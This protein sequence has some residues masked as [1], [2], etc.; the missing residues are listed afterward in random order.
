MKAI[1]IKLDTKVVDIPDYRPVWREL[2]RPDGFELE[3]NY[4]GMSPSFI[5]HELKTVDYRVVRIAGGKDGENGYYLVNDEM[6]FI[7][8]PLIRDIIDSNRREL[9]HT[10][11]ELKILTTHLDKVKTDY[12]STWYIRLKNYAEKTKLSLVKK[13]S[14]RTE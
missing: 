1:L 14:G 5:P 8:M 6:W 3:A 11:E 7:A 10:V 4:D 12:E 13:L 2:V 9:E